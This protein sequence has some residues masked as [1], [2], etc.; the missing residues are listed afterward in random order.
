MF[1]LQ[2][3]PVTTTIEFDDVPSGTAIDN[4]YQA[5]G[6]RF[7]TITTNPPGQSS[8]FATFSALAHTPPNTVSVDPSSWTFDRLLGGVQVTFDHLVYGASIFAL[9]IVT[10]ERLEH[11]DNR[12]FIEAF[13]E[14]GAFLAETKYPFPWWDPNFSSWENLVVTSAATLQDIFT[15]KIKS[16]VFSSQRN[17]APHV[18]AAFDTLR[19]WHYVPA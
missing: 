15:P 12:P 10:L 6:A 4:H 18:L 11:T 9:P 19:F 17:G 3:Y 8:A 7:Q 14:N 13:D 16:V 2:F 1:H 5:M